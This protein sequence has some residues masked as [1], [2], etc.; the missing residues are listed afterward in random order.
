[1]RNKA[2]SLKELLE[3][4]GPRK[5]DHIPIDS[6][7]DDIS[8]QT[9]LSMPASPDLTLS[10]QPAPSSPASPLIYNSPE[11]CADAHESPLARTSI[12]IPP[13]E[14]STPIVECDPGAVLDFE[15]FPTIHHS[16]DIASYSEDA[17]SFC[18]SNIDEAFLLPPLVLLPLSSPFYQLLNSSYRSKAIT[19]LYLSRHNSTKMLSSWS[20]IV[21]KVSVP[22]TETSTLGVDISL[23]LLVE[24]KRPT[25]NAQLGRCI[26]DIGFNISVNITDL[27]G[28]QLALLLFNSRRVSILSA[29]GRSTC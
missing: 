8:V 7:M 19:N 5:E 27:Q 2:W 10:A 18:L 28:R 22:Q 20:I 24:S 6:A 11:S 25:G 23:H 9:D 13:T 26:L 16:L 14:L 15:A 12:G 17:G 29:V 4:C 3:P 1:M 21:C